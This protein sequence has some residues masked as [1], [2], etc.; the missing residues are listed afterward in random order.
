MNRTLLTGLFLGLAVSVGAAQANASVNVDRLPSRFSKELRAQAVQ[1]FEPTPLGT[2][3]AS[4]HGIFRE[5]KRFRKIETSYETPSIVSQFLRSGGLR[6]QLHIERR[7]DGRPAPAPLAIVLNPIFGEN[8]YAQMNRYIDFFGKRGYHVVVFQSTFADAVTAMNPT[9]FPGDLAQE[10]TMHHQV[11]QSVIHTRIGPANVTGATLVGLS[12]GSF[13]GAVLKAQDAGLEHPLINGPVLLLNPPFD[14]LH[15]MNNLD[16]YVREAHE[17]GDT[18]C[19][20]A[21]RPW[22]VTDFARLL[23]QGFLN[24]D[25]STASID[26]SC[27]KGMLSVLGFQGRLEHAAEQLSDSR[28]D[29]RLSRHEIRNITFDTYI[30]RIARVPN[31]MGDSR[32]SH[33]LGLAK[34]RGFDRF[35]ILGSSDDFINTGYD[36][37]DDPSEFY[38]PE[39]MMMVPTGGNTGLRSAGSNARS[40]KSGLWFDCL[41]DRIFKSEK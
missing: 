9:F 29:V 20:S 24:P 15:S 30:N 27:A 23:G 32:L 10:A 14:I 25:A 26:E 5:I 28:E 1:T 18:H 41:L 21:I 34:D 31:L 2:F 17:Q 8:A 7:P 6:V 12:Y 38:S 4:V 37:R 13:L 19:F 33:W 16:R 39:H 22:K 3:G 36:L 35:L 11:I 40:C